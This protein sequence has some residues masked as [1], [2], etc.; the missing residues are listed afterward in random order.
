[1]N[2]FILILGPSG[3]GKSTII[4]KLIANNPKIKYV[5]PVTDRPPREGEHFKISV[6]PEEF[7]RL[8]KSGEFAAINHYFTFRYGTPRGKVQ[9]IF[10]NNQIP[11]LDMILS[12][13][14]KFFE[15]KEVL[16]KI[17]LKP[18][19][20]SELQNRL[21][22]EKRDPTGQRYNEGI[23]ELTELKQ[24]QF[25]H[26]NIDEII[27]NDDLENTYKKVKEVIDQKLKSI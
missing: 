19:T 18:P 20:I 11:I 12:G 15:Y 26:P 23:E 24:T 22:K 13:V 4:K 5:T 1:M 9:E 8:E 3:V 25:N 17:Y 7:T 21:E 16:F 14:P 6:S 27:I 2:P 10:N